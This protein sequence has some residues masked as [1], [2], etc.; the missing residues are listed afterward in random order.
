M[1]GLVERRSLLGAL[2]NNE[3]GQV[4]RCQSQ[5]RAGPLGCRD[6]F[7][8]VARRAGSV[9]GSPL[10]PTSNSQEADGC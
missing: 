9:R 3:P 1:R 7:R 8:V 6:H 4:E 2:R 10:R 5:E